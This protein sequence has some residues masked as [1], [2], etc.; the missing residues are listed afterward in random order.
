MHRDV[1][2][3]QPSSLGR[4]VPG[5][6]L[7]LSARIRTGKAARSVQVSLPLV[8]LYARQ[9]LIQL[10]I[11][12]AKWIQLALLLVRLHSYTKQSQPQLKIP[13]LARATRETERKVLPRAKYQT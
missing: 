10:S 12:C 1:A 4:C 11:H 6:C 8:S 2:R 7:P 13:R 5:P 9:C 3:R